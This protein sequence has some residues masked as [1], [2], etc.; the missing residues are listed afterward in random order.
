MQFRNYNIVETY[1]LANKVMI[2]FILL[3]LIYPLFIDCFELS[4]S[5]QYK[6]LTGK[7]CRS[8]GLT[9]GLLAC[10][11]FDFTQANKLNNQSLFTFITAIC[12]LIFR[13]LYLFKSNWIAKYLK[14]NTLFFF[15]IG[16]LLFLFLFNIFYY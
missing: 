1:I 11:D 7:N 5:C 15:D 2:F 13:I 14:I 10:Y 4:F 9:R 6:L 8:C 16:V 3:I 12:Q